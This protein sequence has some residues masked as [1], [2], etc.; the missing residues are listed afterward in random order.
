[1]T[2]VKRKTRLWIVL[3]AFP[4]VGMLWVPFYNRRDPELAGIPYFY[5][6]QLAWIA[7]SAV[8]TAIVYLATRKE[9]E[10]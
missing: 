1:M 2:P 10:R 4:F 3:L 5:W 6:Y 7:V 8:L 9:E